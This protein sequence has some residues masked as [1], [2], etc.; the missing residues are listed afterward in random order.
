MKLER[1]VLNTLHEENNHYEPEFEVVGIYKA[2]NEDLI[3]N[4][5]IDEKENSALSILDT[6]V[7]NFILVKFETVNKIL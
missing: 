5:E 4:Y 6:D 3:E 7:D 2:Y 1:L